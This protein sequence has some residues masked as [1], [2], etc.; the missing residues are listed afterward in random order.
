MHVAVAEVHVAV[1]EVHVA[2]A[3]VHVA[4]AEVHVAVAEVHV[5]VA[6][7][8]VVVE[9]V[10][11]QFRWACRNFISVYMLVC[12]QVQNTCFLGKKAPFVRKY[13]HAC[14]W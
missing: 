4:V 8:H 11:T 14:M 3:E 10:Y 1:A 6:E 7:V 12:V 9:E 2:V 5:A 13:M